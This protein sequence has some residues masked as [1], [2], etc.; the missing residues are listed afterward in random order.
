MDKSIK[1]KTKELQEVLNLLFLGT[2]TT[3]LSSEKAKCFLF[4]TIDSQV[5]CLASSQNISLSYNFGEIGDLNVC[6]DAKKLKH[7]VDKTKKEEIEFFKKDEDTWSIKGAGNYKLQN[8]IFDFADTFHT[9]ALEEKIFSSLSADLS[10]AM[11]RSIFFVNDERQDPHLRNFYFDGNMVATDKK[12]IQVVTTTIKSENKKLLIP[13]IFYDVCKKLDTTINF[14]EKDSYYVI[15][16][17][18]YRVR[19]NKILGIE[20]FPEYS[21]FLESCESFEN[22]LHFSRIDFLECI[23]RA[24]VFTDKNM[25][26]GLTLKITPEKLSI[27]VDEA[28]KIE[29][30]ISCEATVACDITLNSQYVKEMASIFADETIEMKFNSSTEV[31]LFKDSFS[32]LIL[33][34]VVLNK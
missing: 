3:A 16:S 26:Y 20:K 13:Q 19:L 24:T 17:G 30:E 29:E 18:N 23:E 34:P 2:D 22:T 33:V 1:F 15:T 10:K 28:D 7:L 25:Y 9:D 14:Y 27:L 6:L 5:Y 31:V 21:S 4:K 12:S 32:K 8:F 11:E